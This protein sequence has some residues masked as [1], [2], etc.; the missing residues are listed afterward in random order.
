MILPPPHTP[1]LHVN[2]LQQVIVK[3]QKLPAAAHG[4]HT[5]ST[6]LLEELQQGI[7]TGHFS[8][9]LAQF[10]T[11]VGTA[12]GTKLGFTKPFVGVGELGGTGI[13]IS[14]IIITP[15]A[16]KSKFGLVMAKQYVPPPHL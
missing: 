11:V 12:V 8:P 9:S 14:G 15:S 2:P 1:F 7:W 5:L 3:S 13:V 6:Q 10:I 4:W 16:D